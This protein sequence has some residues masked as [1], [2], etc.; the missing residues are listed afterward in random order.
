M[1]AV[2]YALFEVESRIRALTNDIYAQA[3]PET[4]AIPDELHAELEAALRERDGAVLDLA[5]VLKERRGEMELVKAEAQRLAARAKA[6]AGQCDRLEAAIE[7][8]VPVGERMRDARVTI[9]WRRSAAVEVL[10]PPEML[11][12]CYQ[13]HKVEADKVSLRASLEAGA[14]IPG[15][16]MVESQHLQVR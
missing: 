7:A 11:P 12:E 4:G 14:R 8:R 2:S 6:L 1:A 13:R 16:E 3:D 5:C 15:A 9:S 10:V